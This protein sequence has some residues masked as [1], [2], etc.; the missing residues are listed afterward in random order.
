MYLL[1]VYTH[2]YVHIIYICIYIY[3][4]YKCIH[5]ISVLV[6]IPALAFMLCV[7]KYVYTYMCVCWL[8][9]AWSSFTNFFI[10]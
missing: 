2:I 7:C 9:G 6:R 8:F 5:N 3:T 10:K 4:V 1:L